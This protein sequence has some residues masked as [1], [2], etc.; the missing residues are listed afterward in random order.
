MTKE[1]TSRKIS[2]EEAESNIGKKV[3]KHPK[4][5][6]IPTEFPDLSNLVLKPIP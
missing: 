3:M 4:K 6:K 5:V 2:F 1:T